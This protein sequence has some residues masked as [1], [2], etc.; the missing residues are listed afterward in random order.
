ML[1]FFLIILAV[2]LYLLQRY[3]Y[4]RIWRK[5]ISVSIGFDRDRINEGEDNSVTETITNTSLLPLNCITLRYTL[6][7][8]CSPLS[9]TGGKREIVSRGS[10]GIRRKKIRE[11]S[12]DNLRRGYY[13]VS[14]GKITG[15]DIFSTTEYECLFT[16]H[17][18]FYVFPKKI[19]SLSFD[20]CYR[21][22]L[23]T[24]LSKRRKNEDP[25]E[26]RGI[27]NYRITDSMKNINWKASA[28][29]GSLVVNE[30]DYTTDEGASIVLDLRKGTEEEKERLISYASTV[31]SRF[32]SR[33]IAVSLYTNVRS[34]RD[35]RRTTGGKG[36]G[37]GHG[38]AL[39]ESLALIKSEAV[40]DETPRRMLEDMT[41]RN[42]SLLLITHTLSSVSDA[43]G[44]DGVLC[45]RAEERSTSLTIIET[46]GFDE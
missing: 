35:G 25:F 2:L 4:F 14:E 22:L 39:D 21:E 16:S 24:V 11:Y 44:Y 19:D 32:L 6:L 7:R 15:R 46:E 1:V 41:E 45:F 29:N 31:S 27:R 13:T 33:G 40:I 5:G 10:V 3:L 9:D 18:S 36:S 17:S 30:H 38:N 34:S 28:K 26:L 42:S 37:A 20:L 12:I 43:E 8:L 23:G